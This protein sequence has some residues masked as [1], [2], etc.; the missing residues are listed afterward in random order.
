MSD[1]M[2]I[3]LGLGPYFVAAI[4]LGFALVA[5]L[6]W[7][8]R[9]PH[10]WFFFVLL[11]LNL[12]PVGGGDQDG[13]V[14]RQVSW[15]VVF[16]YAIY[17]AFRDGDG[18][19]R[20]PSEVL[21]WPFVALLAYAIMSIAWSAHPVVSA[22]RL[23][24][25]VGVVVVA[26]AV[27]RVSQHRSRDLIDQSRVPIFVFL[28]IG[29]LIAVVSP[30]TA[31]D[32]DH[33]LKAMTTHKNTWGQFSLL[34]AIILLFSLIRSRQRRLFWFLAF[35]LAAA[36]LYLSRSATSLLAFAAIAAFTIVAMTWKRGGILGWVAIG[37]VVGLGLIAVLAYTIVTGKLPFD[38]IVGAAYSLTGKS[39][40]LSGRTYL[41][42]L[43]LA[44]VSRHW[45]FGTGYG[46]FWISDGMEARAVTSRLN[47]GPPTQAHSGYIDVLNELGVVGLTLL[48]A[49]VAN[50]F[51]RLVRLARSGA[52]EFFF[53]HLSLMVSALIINYAESSL[54]RTTHVWWII[55]CISILDAHQRC[56]G[57]HPGVSRAAARDMRR[58]IPIPVP[59]RA[60]T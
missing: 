51:A 39:D 33:A 53:L 24:Q 41:W 30:S 12:L 50:H 28:A 6:P 59:G 44:E 48:T 58:P 7:L 3:V 5:V 17:L 36:S 8:L 49:V 38:A 26:L 54:L 16:A 15:S 37:T 29:L 55:L 57:I 32:A 4:L 2:L 31:F 40:T 19:W 18:R 47:W 14:F 20:F 56:A 34:A 43:M 27:V 25:L 60:G 13:S 35:I 45:I 11:G 42:Q 9:N 1:P 10:R 46:G 23:L 22:K 52:V 21:P